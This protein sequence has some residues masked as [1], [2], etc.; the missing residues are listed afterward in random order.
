MRQL[1]ILMLIYLLLM[2][3]GAEMGQGIIVSKFASDAHTL[4][5][6]CI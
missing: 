1:F 5:Q 2:L 4:A 6:V 3:P